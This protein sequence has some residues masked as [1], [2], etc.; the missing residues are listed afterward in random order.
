MNPG[1][2]GESD[3][4]RRL[5]RELA[6][7]VRS[8]RGPSPSPAQAAFRRFADRSRFRSLLLTLGTASAK[9]VAAVAA[10]GLVATG[11]VVAATGS[12]N[13]T[14]WGSTVTRAVAT[15]RGSLPS[16]Q[17]GIGPCVS[18][19]A[20][21]NG[22]GARAGQAAPSPIPGTAHV[23]G[24]TVISTPAMGTG[25][26]TGDPGGRPTHPPSTWEP[27]SPRSADRGRASGPTTWPGDSGNRR[28]TAGAGGMTGSPAPSGRPSTSHRASSGNGPTGPDPSPS[29]TPS[30]GWAH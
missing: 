27:S 2:L 21:Q 19:A 29:P 15:C 13:P 22:S 25:T 23:T 1:G 17:H 16:G 4:E 9:A 24:P 28:S 12:P 6:R 20:S 14:V 8:L 5:E 3:L 11:G 18:G 10:A 7:S 26:P 30:A